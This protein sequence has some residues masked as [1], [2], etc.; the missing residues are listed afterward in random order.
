L[1][2]RREVRRVARACDIRRAAPG[3]R[4]ERRRS[5]TVRR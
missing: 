5:W 2:L 4:S 3:W 1:P